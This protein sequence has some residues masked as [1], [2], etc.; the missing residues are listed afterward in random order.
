LD[1]VAEIKESSLE[2]HH[3]SEELIVVLERMKNSEIA[4]AKDIENLTLS[5][6]SLEKEVGLLEKDTGV[7]KSTTLTKPPVHMPE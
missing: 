1:V 5:L 6:G 7:A 2:R 3:A 4:A